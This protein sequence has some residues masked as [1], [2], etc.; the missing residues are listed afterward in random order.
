MIYSG[1]NYP[2]LTVCVR[3]SE[4]GNNCILSNLKNGKW[5]RLERRTLD[6]LLATS[7]EEIKRS[8]VADGIDE[9][10]ATAFVD[11]LGEYGFISD[12]CLEED[13]IF[14][15]SNAYLNVT[16]KCNLSCVHCYNCS[17]P[18]A[19]HGLSVE[20]LQLLVDRLILGGIKRLVIA[21][22]EPMVLPGIEDLLRYVSGKFSEVTLLTNGTIITKATASVIAACVDAVHVSVDG[23][24]EELNAI[25]RGEGNF[26]LAIEGIRLLK[27][28]QTKTV[29]MI[30]N[31]NAANINQA[32]LMKELGDSLGV[33]IGN[34][35]F[36]EVGRGSKCSHLVLKKDELIR[37]FIDEAKG[38]SCS[39]SNET[40]TSL[41]VS[42]GL[43]CGSGTST[44]SVDCFGDVFP[45]HLFHRPDLLIGNLLTQ[46]NLIQ[47]LEESNVVK[48]FREGTVE[49]RK[50]HGC[51]VEYFCK[52]ACLAQTVAAHGDSPD[53]WKERNPLCE[54]H[55]RVLSYQLWP[56]EERE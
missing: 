13:L 44:I 14:L 32:H 7:T 40:T 54:V 9:E 47:M 22:G 1:K 53:P 34:N 28:A 55:R 31:I 27:E 19:Q 20:K 4:Y 10:E 45:C 6:F 52:G 21:G 41:E 25:I 35:I 37:F 16:A 3:I 42:A 49:K 29:R 23:P 46:P 43:S 18:E 50:C 56:S 8:I 51:R 39:T 11:C 48:R 24:T 26:D 38:L 17:S 5:V 36:A 15:P 2:C 30:T 33:E 12:N